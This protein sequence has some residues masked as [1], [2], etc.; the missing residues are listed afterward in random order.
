MF[1]PQSNSKSTRGE[2]SDDFHGLCAETR[3]DENSQTEP[4]LN[5]KKKKERKKEEKS[6]IVFCHTANLLRQ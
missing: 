2:Y 6:D 3:L 4:K 1:L 5:Q